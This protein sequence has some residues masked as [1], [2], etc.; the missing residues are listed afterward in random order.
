[1]AKQTLVIETAKELSLKCG[2]IVIA[3]KESGE[4]T[5]RPI[6][7]LR[8]LIVDNHSVRITVPLI[9]ELVRNNVCIVYCDERH[10]PASMMMDLDSNS[11]QSK[12]FQSQLSASK[13]VNKQLWKQIVE[14]KIRNQSRLIEELGRGER[15]LA[16]Y[17]NNVKSNDTTNREGS[18]ARIYWKALLGKDFV[19]DRYGTAPNA[20]L[21]YGYAL[22]RTAMARSLM[23]AGLLPTVGIFHKN[24]YNAFPLADDM[25]E[26]FRPFVD[27]RVL[28][29]H[30]RGVACVCR[31]TKQEL[32]GLFYSDITES[33]LTLAATTLSGVYEGSNNIVVFPKI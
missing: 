21:N 5:L 33:S 22:L 10:M 12:R 19:R 3:D 30:N 26:P 28:Q 8:T 11:L 6:E 16:K 20:L 29:L 17:Y 4:E 31:E 13:P 18:A 2:M 14:A 32:L 23:N 24:R 1:M 7:D 25:M 15:L 27:R 9:N